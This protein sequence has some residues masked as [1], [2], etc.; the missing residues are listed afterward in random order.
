MLLLVLLLLPLF[1]LAPPLHQCP[2]G[3][4]R[5]WQIPLLQSA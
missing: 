4:G 5:H 2:R 1:V 3:H